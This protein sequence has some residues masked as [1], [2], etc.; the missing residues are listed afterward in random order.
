MLDL[1]IGIVTYNNE[2]IIGDLLKSIY[3]N[4]KDLTFQVYVIDNLSSDHTLDI[5]END[6]PQVTLIKNTG[7]RGFGSGHNQ[8]LRIVSSRYHAIINPDITIQ[9]NVFLFLKDYLDSH[10]DCA[11]VTPRILNQ[12]RT[13]QYLPKMTP[14]F[15][16]M[17]FGRLARYGKFFDDIRAEYTMRNVVFAEPTE[18]QCCTGCFMFVRTE[19][20]KDCGGFNEKFFMYL[21]DAEL[22]SRVSTY[23]KVIFHPDVSVVHQW[24]R[25]SSKSIKF[26]WIHFCSMLKFLQMK[27]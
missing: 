23:G 26:F 17:V 10:G 25:E 4:T 6:F 15:K 18:I 14:N 2:G 13:E 20:W 9:S 21:E 27:K 7:N 1:S 12:D 11:M 16:Y 22:T 24:N 19:I 5:I 3:T 8:L